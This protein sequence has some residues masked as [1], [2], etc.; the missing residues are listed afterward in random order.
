MCCLNATIGAHSL[1]NA[2]GSFVQTV[3]PH[4]AG[5]TKGMLGFMFWVAECS[6]S[7]SPC[8]A[9]PNTCGAGIGM[10]AY[11]IP[12]PMPPSDRIRKERDTAR[13]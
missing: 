13:A 4:G 8:T 6:A 12:M 9:T 3:Q 2:T 10:G 5:K 1:E 7:K 11:H